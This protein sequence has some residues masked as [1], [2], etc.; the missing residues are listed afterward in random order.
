MDP[1]RFPEHVHGY[2]LAMPPRR[3]PSAASARFADEVELCVGPPAPQPVQAADFGLLLRGD[4]TASCGKWRILR[5]LPDGRSSGL[6]SMVR[7]IDVRESRHVRRTVGSFGAS[8]TRTIMLSLGEPIE[9]ALNG[10]RFVDRESFLVGSHAGPLRTRHAGHH[11]GVQVDL[12]PM[13]AYRLTGIPGAKLADCVVDLAT[14]T[15]RLAGLEENLAACAGPRER[16]AILERALTT[17][18]REGPEPDPLVVWLWERLAQDHGRTRISEL[19]A[20]TG[21]SH[22]HVASR[23]R[24]QVGLTPK[25]AARILRF[26]LAVELLARGES[27]SLVAAS[28]GYSDQSHLSREV[29]SLGGSPPSTV[30]ASSEGR[31]VWTH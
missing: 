8:T 17:A 20:E 13:A 27:A 15:N 14:A 31:W 3:T 5:L 11:V 25:T 9:V 10:D 22:R 2:R 18:I 23:F 26:E 21:F 29:S 16:L 6:G 24:E 19:V 12:E 7:R 30:A 4:S 28:C 1:Y